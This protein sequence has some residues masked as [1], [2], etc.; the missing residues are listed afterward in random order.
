MYF[1]ALTIPKLHCV[2]AGQ[3]KA[4]GCMLTGEHAE[5]ALGILPMGA[6]KLYFAQSRYYGRPYILGTT[7]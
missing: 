7:L 2:R 1:V 5:V 4:C 3:H 6:G